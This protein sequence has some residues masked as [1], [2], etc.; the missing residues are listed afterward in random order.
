MILIDN[1]LH[2]PTHIIL[3]MHHFW[4]IA[5][6]RKWALV[7]GSYSCG[8]HEENYVGFEVSRTASNFKFCEFPVDTVKH[9]SPI[10]ADGSLFVL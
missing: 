10:P 5:I 1:W 9:Y 3:K 6:P 8:D 4:S 2:A 7:D